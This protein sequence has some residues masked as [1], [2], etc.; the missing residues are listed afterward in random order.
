[1]YTRH[2]WSMR[3]GPRDVAIWL[4]HVAGPHGW[5][6]VARPHEVQCFMIASHFWCSTCHVVLPHGTKTVVRHMAEHG[7]SINN[8]LNGPTMSAKQ[9]D[10]CM[11]CRTPP[12]SWE[13]RHQQP[14]ECRLILRSPNTTILLRI[15]STAKHIETNSQPG[16]C[17]YRPWRC[18]NKVLGQGYLQRQWRCR[19][20]ILNKG[21][22]IAWAWRT[23]RKDDIGT[24]SATRTYVPRLGALK[25]LW[26]GSLSLW[27]CP[28]ARHS[29]MGGH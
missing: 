28:R 24:L 10:A 29:G 25:G 12:S 26:I 1:M 21:C 4:Q 13:S 16:P 19:Q 6:P 15:S 2:L 5:R 11:P 14:S 3:T 18:F 20:H 27:I 7:W 9:G 17:K 23:N 22:S 8:Q